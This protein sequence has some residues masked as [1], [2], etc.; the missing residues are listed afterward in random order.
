[1]PKSDKFFIRASIFPSLEFMIDENSSFCVLA[2][3][4]PSII[5]SLI[6]KFSGSFV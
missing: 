3:L 4:K 1:M 2:R 5:K 6:N